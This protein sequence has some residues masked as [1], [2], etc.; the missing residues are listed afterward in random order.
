[1]SIMPKLN[2]SVDLDDSPQIANAVSSSRAGSPELDMPLLMP[3][4]DPAPSNEPSDAETMGCVV[5]MSIPVKLPLRQLLRHKKPPGLSVIIPT[6]DSLGYD[7]AGNFRPTSPVVPLLVP[8]RPASPREERANMY[9]PISQASDTENQP[10]MEDCGDEKV[11]DVMPC[12]S[13]ISSPGSARSTTSEHLA[14]PGDMDRFLLPVSEASLLQALPT[15]YPTPN[16]SSGWELYPGGM[17]HRNAAY[18]WTTDQFLRTDGM[19]LNVEDPVD[20][21][22][23]LVVNEPGQ[24][25]KR[26]RKKLSSPRQPCSSYGNASRRTFINEDLS[27]REVFVAE[28]VFDAR[29]RSCRG[30]RFENGLSLETAAPSLLCHGAG[31]RRSDGDVRQMASFNERSISVPLDGRAGENLGCLFVVS[32]TYLFAFCLFTF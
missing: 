22:K 17:D 32:L 2:R 26:H 20:E 11:N 8:P 31:P 12:F 23:Q 14:N 9:S 3:E 10:S 21:D 16:Y 28:E 1:M 24:S 6:S 25:Q 7:D 30:N 4:L 15:R 5:G 18:P 13:P 29:T 19:R 27:A